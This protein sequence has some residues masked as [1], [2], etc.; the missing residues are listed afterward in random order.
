M[1]QNETPPWLVVCV[2]LLLLLL[3]LHHITAA[4]AQLSHPEERKPMW[5]LGRPLGVNKTPTRSY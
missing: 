5:A 4:P 1:T 3:L 2:V